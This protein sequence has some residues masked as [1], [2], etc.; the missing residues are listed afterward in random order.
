MTYRI[1]RIDE[2]TKINLRGWKIIAEDGSVLLPF[3]TRQEAKRLIEFFGFEVA[4]T[5][6]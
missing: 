5:E 4:G 3:T 1:A 2:T 6:E